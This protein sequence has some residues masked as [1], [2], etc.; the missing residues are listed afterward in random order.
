M[1]K[2]DRHTAMTIELSPEQEQVIGEAIHA[3]LI[4]K[5]SD[6]IA[7]GVNALEEKLEA[8]REPEAA[9]EADEWVRE[10]HSW[11]SGHSTSTPVLSNASLERDSIYGMR[12]H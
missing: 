5:P 7:I 6:V 11:V 2:W 4:L 12:G 9:L 1:K 3:G 8:R 10:L